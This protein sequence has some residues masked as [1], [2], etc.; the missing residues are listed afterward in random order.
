VPE[1]DRV[2]AY[3]RRI[4]P[5][6]EKE[7]VARAHLAFWTELARRWR[8]RR[9]LEIGSGLGRITVAL[10]RHS[11]AVGADISLEMLARACRS[12]LHRGR[13]FFVAADMR[14]AAF[15]DAF[16]LIVAP[17]DPFSHLVSAADRKKA[18]RMIAGQLSLRGRFVLEA[19][20]RPRRIPLAVDRRFSYDGGELAIHETWRPLA[21][22]S[23]WRARFAYCDR[24]R[25]G[26]AR[27]L[28]ASFTA[29]CWSAKEIP[30][31]FASCGLVVCAL[32]GSWDQTPFAPDAPHLIV[33]AEKRDGRT[34]SRTGR[35]TRARR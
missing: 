22:K 24:P 35:K 33:V 31:L 18:L 8:P 9:V 14:T 5:F 4:L 30:G 13:P 28:A 2:L 17:S 1:R 25:G 23:L 26:A 10:E 15:R 19:L 20:Y 21:K 3:Y 6:Y 16:D 7:S 32:W 12:R 11:P 29:R 34:R 27:R